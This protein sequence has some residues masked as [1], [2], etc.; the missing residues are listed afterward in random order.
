MKI[1]TEF[2]AIVLALAIS[3]PSFADEIP[4]TTNVTP[5]PPP[6]SNLIEQTSP[7]S[8]YVN[9]EARLSAP[10]YVTEV[11]Q[12]EEVQSRAMQ[13]PDGYKMVRIQHPP[14]Y[15]C[16][17]YAQADTFE[18]QP[19][20]VSKPAQQPATITAAQENKLVSIAEDEIVYVEK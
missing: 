11:P 4:G 17:E 13:V 14:K 15:V 1:P 8:L 9:H 7:R 20:A 12:F 18:I 10:V 2:V 3:I 6:E 19:I 16:S 5:V